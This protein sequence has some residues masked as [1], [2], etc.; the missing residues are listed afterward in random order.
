MD[1]RFGF[2][3]LLLTVF[4]LGIMVSIWL[5]MKQDDRQWEMLQRVDDR[6]EQQ[7]RTLHRIADL[8]EQGVKVSSAGIGVDPSQARPTDVADSAPDDPFYR[9]RTA[10]DQPDYTRGDWL[11]DAFSVAVGKLTP[12]VSQDVYAR[13][14]EDLVLE[15]LA[16]R[17]PDTLEWMPMIAKSW[18]VNEDGLIIEFD[19][20]QDVRFSDGQLLTADDVIFTYEWIM[21]PKVAAPRSRAYFEKIDSVAKEGDYRVIFTLK[22]PYFQSFEICAGMAIMARHYYSQFT[23]EQYNEMTGLLFGSG[24]YVLAVDPKQWKPG[25]GKIELIPNERYWGPPPAFDRVV[26][27]EI[28][29]DTA[30]LTTF[31]NGDIDRYSPTPEQYVTLRDDPVI[32]ERNRRYEYETIRGGYRYIA[33][34]QRRDGQPTLFADKRVRLALT[35][36]IDKQQICDRLMVGLATPTTG[37]FHRLGNQ[38]SPNIEPWPFNPKAAIGLLK[39]AGFEDRDGDGVIEGPDGRPFNFKLIYPASSGNYQQMAFF[40]K[41]AFARAGIVLEPDPLEWTIMIQRIQQRDY[42]AMTLGWSGSIESDPYQI[43]HSSQVSDGGDNYIYY[44]SPELDEVLEEA[45]VTMDEDQRMALW[46]RCHEILHEDQPYTFLFTMKAVNFVNNRIRNV[47]QTTL[48]LNPL[49]EWYVPASQ[50]K[51]TP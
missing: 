49:L 43:F 30:R 21:N 3:D 22:E 15:S 31:T 12:L 40:L 11:I 2:R 10:M 35:M 18:R 23:P 14:I 19:L 4:L 20:R 9:I 50:Q 45:R 25:S 39:D 36:L 41:D 47:Q 27:R 28:L 34:N 51:R 38:D 37:P 26:Y 17:D 33:W 44:V 16:V 13:I 42:D 29:D 32:N 24:P 46:H 5:S 7:G 6:L 8:L 1:N 48:G